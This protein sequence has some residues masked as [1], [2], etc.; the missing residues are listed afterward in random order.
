MLHMLHHRAHGANMKCPAFLQ[1]VA[2]L[3]PCPGLEENSFCERALA[4]RARLL[5]LSAQALIG[6][7]QMNHCPLL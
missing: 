4:R 7:D 3:N 2:A 1:P 6:L 5:T